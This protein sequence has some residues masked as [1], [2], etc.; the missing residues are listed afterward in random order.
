[1]FRNA[2]LYASISDQ[3]NYVKDSSTHNR[4][5][6]SSFTHGIDTLHKRREYPTDFGWVTDA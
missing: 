6:E 3:W 2:S 4:G 1:M 5:Y